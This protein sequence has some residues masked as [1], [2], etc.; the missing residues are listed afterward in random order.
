MYV[1]AVLLII[2]IRVTA[3]SSRKLVTL[4]EADLLLRALHGQ[5]AGLVVLRLL[6]NAR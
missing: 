5:Q 2:R 6:D 4:Y 3:I 1:F